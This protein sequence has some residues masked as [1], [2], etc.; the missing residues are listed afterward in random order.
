MITPFHR[1]IVHAAA[2]YYALLRTDFQDLCCPADK[3]GRATRRRLGQVADMGF[4]GKCRMEV[5]NPADH[6]APMPA[7]FPLRKGLEW[8]A[9]DT[10]DES[11]LLK[12]CLTPNWQQDT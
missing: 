4:I 12:C 6:E 11:W 10:G 8:L 3:D 1:S 7:Y 2:N 9:A 5:V